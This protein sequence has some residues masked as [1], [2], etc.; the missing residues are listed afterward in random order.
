MHLQ[1]EALVGGALRR[2]RGGALDKPLLCKTGGN[3]SYNWTTSVCIASLARW[4]LNIVVYTRLGRRPTWC[5]AAWAMP[6]AQI[7]GLTLENRDAE[8]QLCVLRGGLEH[9]PHQRALRERIGRVGGILISNG[10][11][12]CPIAQVPVQNVEVEG[13]PVLFLNVILRE[14][15]NAATHCLLLGEPFLLERFNGSIV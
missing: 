8:G 13:R 7:G 9:A 3:Y 12:A 15:G 14:A 11:I 2:R 6:H 10:C 4:A 5:N 1:R